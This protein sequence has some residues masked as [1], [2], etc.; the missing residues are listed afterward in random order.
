MYPQKV[1]IMPRITRKDVDFMNKEKKVDESYLGCQN[2]QR[3]LRKP[4]TVRL[5]MASL[6][7]YN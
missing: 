6:T 3:S 2:G 7:Q 1:M 5:E 4:N